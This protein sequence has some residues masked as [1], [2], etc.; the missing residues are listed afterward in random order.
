[1]RR[2]IGT[3]TAVA[4]AMATLMASVALAGCTS[5][6]GADDPVQSEQVVVQEDHGLRVPQSGMVDESDYYLPEPGE[7]KLSDE[8][9]WSLYMNLACGVQWKAD[10][11]DEAFAT[12][13]MAKIHSAAEAYLE[14][15]GWVNDILDAGFYD[16]PEESLPA[17]VKLRQAV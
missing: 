10:A 16:W 14:A 13:D 12:K 9:A 15:V 3:A 6:S 5:N 2:T 11:Q 17:L 4:A 8:E 7:M 1:M